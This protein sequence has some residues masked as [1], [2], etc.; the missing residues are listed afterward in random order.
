MAERNPTPTETIVGWLRT[1]YPD[2]VPAHD[3]VALLGILHRSLTDAEV[4]ELAAQLQHDDDRGE[5][6]IRERI[7]QHALEE[8]SDE[9][10]RRVA[11]RLAAGGWPLDQAVSVSTAVGRG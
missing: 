5:E 9:D 11:S 1:G 4:T 8:P 10:I 6:A 7:R 2:G 3:Y